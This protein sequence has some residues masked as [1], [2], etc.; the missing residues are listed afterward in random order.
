[1][2]DIIQPKSPDSPLT[3]E[4]H[5]RYRAGMNPILRT[6]LAAISPDAD[7]RRVAIL[8]I[9]AGLYLLREAGGPASEPSVDRT[10]T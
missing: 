1:M 9:N 7:R 5:W 2:R 4:P 6:I 10:Q 8:L 3:P